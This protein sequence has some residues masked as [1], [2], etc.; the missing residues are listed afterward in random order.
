MRY[1]DLNIIDQ[2]KPANW[3]EN[4]RVWF[5]R[6]FTAA[7]KSTEIKAIGNK[8]SQFKVN[9][10]NSFGDKCWYSEVPRV[11]TDFDVDHF[12]PKCDVKISKSIYASRIVNG[13]SQNHSGYWWLAFE[14]RNYR[15]ACIEANRL[16]EEG[17]KHDYFPLMDEATR[18][19][20]NTPFSGHANELIKLLDPCNRMDVTLISYV[21]DP[22]KITSRYSEDTHPAEYERVAESIKRY[23][24]NSKTVKG[25]R[26]EIIKKVEQSLE[27][28]KIYHNMQLEFRQEYE[29]F[30]EKMKR[31]IIEACDRKSA[32]SASAVA[33]VRLKQH[34]PWLIH[35][36]PLIDL[37]D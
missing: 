3:D 23:N 34:E 22:G 6:V 7:N 20:V 16:R 29:V 14:A 25:A 5:Q 4:A 37:T 21:E 15:Y 10:I 12:R 28:L 33:F 32:F 24:L 8:W 35:L 9:F 26:G 13:V 2:C 31:N 18:V 30:A 27:F 36:L 11:G 17:G 1:I 19:W